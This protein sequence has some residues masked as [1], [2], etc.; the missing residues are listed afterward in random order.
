M[1]PATG[2]REAGG[3]NAIDVYIRVKRPGM[4]SRFFGTEKDGQLTPKLPATFLPN[5]SPDCYPILPIKGEKQKVSRSLVYGHRYAR[6]YFVQCY[7]EK[8]RF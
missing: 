3:N 4:A 6:A 1:G 2:R 8:S 7:P 5:V